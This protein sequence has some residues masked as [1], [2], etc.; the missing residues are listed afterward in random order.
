LDRDS[1]QPPVGPYPAYPVVASLQEA[2]EP[3][4]KVSSTYTLLNTGAFDP[5]QDYSLNW[6]AR[7]GENWGGVKL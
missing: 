6:T 3:V 2:L 7:N 1:D 4:R 5:Q